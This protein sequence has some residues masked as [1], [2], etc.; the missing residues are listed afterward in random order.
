VLGGR[1]ASATIKNEMKALPAQVSVLYVVK[2]SVTPSMK[3][4]LIVV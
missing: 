2:C 1:A 3:I 4:S